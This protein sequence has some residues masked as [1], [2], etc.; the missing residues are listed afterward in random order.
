MKRKAILSFILVLAMLFTS[1]FPV[2]A[3]KTT[4]L[5]TVAADD[6]I[7]RFTSFFENIADRIVELWNQ[8]DIFF[9]VKSEG[10]QNTKNV[11]Y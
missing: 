5:A 2:S 3:A 7:N 10:V 1:A 8:I 6:F 9:E 4:Q 11:K